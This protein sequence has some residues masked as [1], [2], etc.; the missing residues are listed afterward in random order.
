MRHIKPIL[1][2]GICIFYFTAL[3][4]QLSTQRNDNINNF[5]DEHYYS[6]KKWSVTQVL[7]DSVSYQFFS[8]LWDA[9]P[10]PRMTDVSMINISM[11]EYPPSPILLKV[12]NKLQSHLDNKMALY[13]DNKRNSYWDIHWGGPKKYERPIVNKFFFLYQ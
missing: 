12:S 9:S 7:K 4:A 11:I 6:G 1:C 2:T 3:V 5:V 13:I 10:T 8:V